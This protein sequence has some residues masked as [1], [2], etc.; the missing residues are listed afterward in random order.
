MPEAQIARRLR[1]DPCGGFYSDFPAQKKHIKFFSFPAPEKDCVQS[2][3]G[4]GEGE[5]VPNI[6][7]R[8]EL[9]RRGCEKRRREVKP[10]GRR[11]PCPKV[12]WRSQ[13]GP[14]ARLKKST[15]KR[16]VERSRTKK[17]QKYHNSCPPISQR[18]FQQPRRSKKAKSFCWARCSCVRARCRACVLGVL[19]C[20]SVHV[21]A[22]FLFG[23]PVRACGLAAVRACWAC[24]GAVRRCMHL[25]A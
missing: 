22:G 20:I 19:G 8:C 10:L 4:Q 11:G 25:R 14:N 18:K 6:G 13:P 1:F 2:G 5:R 16:S 12:S 7:P 21:R 9:G 24:F 15:V 17:H 3:Q 23:R